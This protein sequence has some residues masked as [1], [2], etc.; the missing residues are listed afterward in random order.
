[1]VTAS[2][3]ICNDCLQTKHNMAWRRIHSKE[4][5]KKVKLRKDPPKRDAQSL[6]K[7]WADKKKWELIESKLNSNR[8]HFS[9]FYQLLPFL[10]NRPQV[11]WERSFAE[12]P[13]RSWI[14]WQ[15][16]IWKASFFYWYFIFLSKMVQLFEIRLYNVILETDSKA[17]K[18]RYCLK[19]KTGQ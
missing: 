6:V 4:R 8:F 12:M 16:L 10:G 17:G 13:V 14:Q 2:H 7:S 11:E 9:W 3:F 19:Y 5:V 15:P 18:V 1:M